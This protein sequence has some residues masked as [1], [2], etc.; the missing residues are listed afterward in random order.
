[1]TVFSGLSQ[2]SIFDGAI[3]NGSIFGEGKKRPGIY[4]VGNY[5]GN[6][7]KIFDANFELRYYAIDEDGQRYPE[8]GYSVYPTG[9]LNPGINT[10]NMAVTPTTQTYYKTVTLK[11]A[12][13]LEVTNTPNQ[14]AWDLENIEA[15][16]T[17]SGGAWSETIP[18]A[19]QYVGIRTPE[20]GEYGD[21]V[22]YG[23]SVDANGTVTAASNN[24]AI[25]A[26]WTPKL[27]TNA[28]RIDGANWLNAVEPP[29][30]TSGHEL[31][32]IEYYPG[33]DYMLDSSGNLLYD[34]EGKIGF[35]PGALPAVQVTGLAL[36]PGANVIVP[37]VVA[38]SFGVE[39]AV[40]GFDIL[41]IPKLKWDGE[42]TIDY[43]TYQIN[44]TQAEYGA[45]NAI[46]V[47]EGLSNETTATPTEA[48]YIFEKPYGVKTVQASYTYPTGGSNTIPV[49]IT[50]NE[51]DVPK[52]LEL[53]G[54]DVTQGQ[55]PKLNIAGGGTISVKWLNS[56]N[57]EQNDT[58]P[59]I[60]HENATDVTVTRETTATATY[61]HKTGLPIPT[62][63]Y[64][65]DDADVRVDFNGTY[66]I[67]DTVVNQPIT[68]GWSI[69]NGN[70][71]G[72]V[73]QSEFTQTLTVD[74]ANEIIMPVFTDDWGNSATLASRTQSVQ[75]GQSGDPD[76]RAYWD[77]TQGDGT[78][79][80]GNGW[81]A[82]TE[83]GQP[84]YD[85]NGVNFGG[86]DN[87]VVLNSNGEFYNKTSEWST[88]VRCI[89]LNKTSQTLMGISS[90][91]TQDRSDIYFS[92][93]DIY[94]YC[95][96]DR[97]KG[98]SYN[99]LTEYEITT[100]HRDTGGGVF[101]HDFYIN[102]VL[103]NTYT[104]GDVGTNDYSLFRFG[105]RLAQSGSD[106]A[107]ISTLANY[108]SGSCSKAWYYTKAL[109]QTEI[110]NL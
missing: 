31:I 63:L 92:T 95:L 20:A 70:V 17:I 21:Y 37:P 14:W 89:K 50:Y 93:L 47:D 57:V 41:R 52:I 71:V 81:D 58:D 15:E 2:G 103:Q 49:P 26:R 88:V 34:N 66:E 18:G 32:D 3:F 106:V 90:N 62:L 77:F 39:K 80:T 35:Q 45:V 38:D 19:R 10:V 110:D 87:L 82:I 48:P 67:P 76:L 53:D 7:T 30:F 43:E 61:S 75:Y 100:V 22:F 8:T 13:T 98:T 60:A 72:E 54:D 64:Y 99:S 44:E 73:E 84:T 4:L 56:S 40:E 108:F 91:I 105:A 29:I 11:Y 96:N 33:A 23:V 68:F 69:T 102:K 27:F 78:D 85:S 6:E 9:A 107:G 42:T 94:Q 36:N 46:I 101:V 55:I 109:T 104:Q 79:L 24:G 16:V 59:V 86:A 83:N 12:T 25:T 5:P 51:F 1:M 65:R 74:S 97:V 28:Y